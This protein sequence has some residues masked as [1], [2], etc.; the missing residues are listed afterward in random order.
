MQNEIKASLE[1]IEQNLKTD[2]TADELAGR[3]NYSTGHFCRLFAQAMGSTVAGYILKRRLDHALAEISSG[4]KAIGVVLEYGFDTYP[5]FYKAF[6]KMYGCSPKKYLSI[7]KK[8]EVFAMK[9]EKDIRDILENWDIPGGLKVEN[10]SSRHWK[11]NE[12]EWQIWKIGDDLYLKTNERSKMVKNIRIAKALQKE[13]LL[14]E[15]LPVPTKSGDDYV[16]GKHIYLLTKKVGEP[17][18]DRPLSGDELMHMEFNRNREKYAYQLGQ[19][20]AKLHR[21]LK[22]IQDDVKPYEANMY[23]QGLDAMQ[24]VKEYSAKH[25]FKISE[26][27][28]EDYEKNFGK[29]YEKIPKQLIH[30]NLTGDSVVYENGEVTGLKGYEIYNVSHVRLFDITWCAGE[31]SLQQIESYLTIL[32]DILKGYNSLNPLT[33]EEKQSGYYMLCVSAMNSVA[34]VDDDT[35]DVLIRNIKALVFLADNKEMF[36]NLI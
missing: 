1:Y 22:S 26:G 34:Y 32:K 10:I 20:V 17:L 25:G 35:F 27:F 14:S 2:I 15:F 23:Q 19:A 36:F 21:A 5:G 6:V 13:G 7:Y 12:I 24:K 16:D 9:N 30:G 29:L 11:T 18:I 28:F 33:E 31:V 8:S 3:V 4:R